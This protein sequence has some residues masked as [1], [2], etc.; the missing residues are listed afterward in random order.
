MLRYSDVLLMLAE[1]ENE[2]T[3]PTTLAHE[4]LNLVRRRAGLLDTTIA[5]QDDFRT[6]VRN[7]RARELCFEG[8]RKPDLIRWGIFVQTMQEVA[9]EFKAHATSTY[10]YA[11]QNAANVTDRHLLYPIP[12]SEM[13]L[14][15]KMVQNPNW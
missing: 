4:C 10:N 12:L 5:S 14:N 15:K 6:E 11:T 7:E 9:D 2:A 8:L 3:G 1:A 13:S